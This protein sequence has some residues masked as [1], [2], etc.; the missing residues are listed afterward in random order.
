MP[1]VSV[2]AVEATITLDG[3]EVS[4]TLV[5]PASAHL[6]DLHH[7]IQGSFAWWN[8]HLHQ[9][10]FTQATASHTYEDPEMPD[11]DLT[12][13]HDERLMT[14]ALTEHRLNVF[15]PGTPAPTLT[16]VYDYGDCWNCSVTLKPVTVA[17]TL[18]KT[19]TAAYGVAPCEDSGGVHG[20]QLHLEQAAQGDPE[21]LAWF[22]FMRH[23]PHASVTPKGVNAQWK[24]YLKG[25][26]GPRSG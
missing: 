23:D 17:R 12:L 24:R 19:C 8:A 5:L 10:I 22:K 25:E 21:T 26:I 6:G 16:Y 9:F 18:L 15:W 13:V 3:L 2:S 11:C 7:A 1:P 14:L 20:Y 4:R